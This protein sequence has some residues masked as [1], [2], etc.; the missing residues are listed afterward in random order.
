[1]AYLHIHIC[2]CVVQHWYNN[3]KYYFRLRYIPLVQKFMEGS[4]HNAKDK[5]R[6]KRVVFPY[7]MCVHCALHRHTER[8]ILYGRAK[9]V[10]N[11][12]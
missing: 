3:R 5:Y 4:A 7:I 11:N 1:M 6:I 2:I 9:P 8:N 12:I 10:C